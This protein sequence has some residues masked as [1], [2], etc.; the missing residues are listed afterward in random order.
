MEGVRGCVWI[1]SGIAQLRWK[2]IENALPVIRWL[3][4]G[5]NKDI[6]AASQSLRLKLLEVLLEYYFNIYMYWT[7]AIRKSE[8]KSVTKHPIQIGLFW[9]NK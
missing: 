1:F 7:W 3:V 6:G 4:E 9:P 2:E 5:Q 8:P